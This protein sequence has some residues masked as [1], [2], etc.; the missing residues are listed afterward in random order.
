MAERLSKQGLPCPVCGA[1][2]MSD[3]QGIQIDYCAQ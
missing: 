2:L 3:R 1:D